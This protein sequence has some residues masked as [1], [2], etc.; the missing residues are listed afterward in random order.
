MIYKN[1][2]KN[3][4]RLFAPEITTNTNTQANNKRIG[5]GGGE[6]VMYQTDRCFFSH[7]TSCK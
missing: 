5:W 2:F 4:L 7:T 1:N 3:P 6:V